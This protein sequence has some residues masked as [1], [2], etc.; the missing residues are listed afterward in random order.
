MSIRCFRFFVFHDKIRLFQRPEECGVIWHSVTDVASYYRG[1]FYDYDR[2]DLYA[3]SETGIFHAPGARAGLSAARAIP[4]PIRW[5]A[6]SSSRTDAS[7]ARAGTST[8][9]ACTPSAMPSRTAR[10]TAAG[11]DLYVTLEP[12]CHWGRTPPCTDAS[13]RARY[14][15]RVRRLPRPQP[16]GCR[17]GRRDSARNAGIEVRDRRVRGRVP[18]R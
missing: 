17:Q 6:A 3:G 10:K 9:A 16:A 13:H 15:P 2:G 12:C 11:A 14:P 1:V 8:S 4:T 7:S 18:T 5:S